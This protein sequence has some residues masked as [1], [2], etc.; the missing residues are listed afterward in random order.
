MK[1]YSF[2]PR[3]ALGVLV[4]AA[5]GL[6]NG[7]FGGGGGMLLLP[8]L[9]YLCRT[10]PEEL[11]PMG[12]CV[13]IPVCILSLWISAAGTP[14]PWDQALPYL[15]GS[16]AGGVAAGIAGKRI[17]VRWLHRILGIILLWGGVRYLW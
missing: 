5:A 14:L 11:F 16:A 7:L 15:L 6:I 3:L 10:E 2:D 1:K 4:G 17:P 13:M 12:V 8:G 9:E